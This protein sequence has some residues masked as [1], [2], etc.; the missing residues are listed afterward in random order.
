V[1]TQSGKDDRVTLAYMASESAHLYTAEG[2]CVLEVK[3]SEPKK[4]ALTGEILTMRKPTLADARKLGLYP[5]WS[6]VKGSIS[7]RGLD[8][9]KVGKLLDAAWK[10]KTHTMEEGDWKNE[11][12]LQ[13]QED[14]ENAAKLG[15]AIHAEI[16]AYIR[17]GV[18]PFNPNT[19]DAAK[20]I[21]AWLKQF[22]G[23]PQ[24]EVSRT[25]TI[26][27]KA[28]TIDIWIPGQLIADIKT[29]ED[30]TKF[31]GCY[32]TWGGQLAWYADILGELPDAVQLVNIIVDRNT[33]ATKFCRWG[34]CPEAKWSPKQCHQFQDM[35]WQI[36]K[37]TNARTSDKQQ[38]GV[39]EA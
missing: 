4:D 16:E 27:A 7:N 1:T 14:G 20:A 37:F 15:T 19:A 23:K 11:V 10:L 39:W 36:W 17:T 22:E 3:R 18:E 12:Y 29:Q 30:I 13:A 5:S 34:D 33:G 28:G 26:K 35:V 38:K 8:R 32:E 25:N 6:L 24:A 9:W 21:G 2:K 31:R